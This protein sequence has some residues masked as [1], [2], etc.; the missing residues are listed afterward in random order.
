MAQPL[1]FFIPD[2]IFTP[3]VKNN[4]VTNNVVANSAVVKTAHKIKKSNVQVN[5]SYRVAGASSLVAN[6]WG[7]AA[8]TNGD[9]RLFQ[10]SNELVIDSFD[11]IQASSKEQL[12][13]EVYTPTKAVKD[14]YG[15]SLPSVVYLQVVSSN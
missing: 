3:T 1:C 12:A 9:L 15:V 13:E 6:S 2:H 10:V 5:S 7:T 4:A 8:A 14:G 11:E